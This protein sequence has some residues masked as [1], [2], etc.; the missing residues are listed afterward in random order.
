MIRRLA[1]GAR[2][3]DCFCNTGGFALNA[4]RGGAGSVL[5]LDSSGEAITRARENARL[6]GCDTIVFEEVDVFAR[7]ESLKEA[8]ETFDLVILDP[9]SF[10]RSRKSVPS[11]KRGYRELHQGAF[12]VL[13]RGGFLVTA[14]CSHHIEPGVFADVVAEAALRSG[15]TL[16]LLEWRGA[17]PDH[18]VLPGVPET[19][20][21]KLGV[22]RSL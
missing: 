12:R 8:S 17:S 10:T 9:P 2:V 20:Y 16:Q 3:L 5:A 1:A 15:R 18:P 7:L 4:T 19:A 22:Y 14:S 11:A 13:K 21:L 6:N